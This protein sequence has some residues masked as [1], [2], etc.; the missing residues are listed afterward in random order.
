MENVMHT[1]EADFLYAQIAS[2]I[3]QQIQQNLLKPGD[4]LPS[5]RALSHEQGISISTAYKAYVELENMGL[6]EARPKSGYY[7]KFLPARFTKQP[8]HKHPPEKI[9]QASVAEMIAMV[10]H[11]M[12]EEDVLRLSRSSPSINLIP[13]AKLN[14]SMLEAMRKSPTGNVNY[15]KLQGNTELRKQV[16]KL[17]FNWGGR[18]TEEDVVTTQG[19]MEALVF[20]LRAVTNSGDTVAIES[21]TYFAIFEIMQSMGL[22]VLEIPVDPVTGVDIEYL[23]QAITKVDIKACLFVSNFSNPVGS[24]MPDARKQ[25]LVTLLAGKQIPLIEDDIYGEIYFGKS[26]PRTC[27]SFD[28]EGWVMLCASVSKSLAPGYRVGWCIPGRFKAQVINIKMMHTISSAT[29]TQA[30][31]AHFFET[32]RYDLHMRKLRKALFTQCLRYSQAIATYFPPGTKISQPQ[33]GYALW[34]QL[35]EKI[36]AFEL[37]QSAMAQNISIAPGQIFSTDARFSNFIRISF[38]I[39]Y[40]SVIEEGIK[41]LGKLI[42]DSI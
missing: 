31:I 42:A 9:A 5:V 8:E 12:A 38:G 27:Q 24:C 18:I 2:R 16:A 28:T 34:I 11:N 4:K 35:H 13:V 1:A 17:A 36:N 26:R 15:E 10:Y 40:D 33:G 22:N 20:C 39:T 29:P 41:T 7:V 32:G 37:Y 19:C 14:K 25:Q 21:P 23:E 30:A 6:I 3:A